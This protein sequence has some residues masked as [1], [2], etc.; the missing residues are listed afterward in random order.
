MKKLL[1]VLLT[2]ILIGCGSISVRVIHP[3]PVLGIYPGVRYDCE[4]TSAF[5]TSE[6]FTFI[7][8]MDIPFS[9]VVDTVCFPYDTYK[10]FEFRNKTTG[11]EN[12]KQTQK[13]II[14]KFNRI[15]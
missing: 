3:L 13:K 1:F 12:P 5:I 7:Y 10:Y 14:M 11:E 15:S 6:P 9:F 8:V 4:Y 2:T